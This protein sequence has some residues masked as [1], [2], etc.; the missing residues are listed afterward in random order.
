[1]LTRKQMRLLRLIH[2]FV[3]R[4]G[5]A[6]S[7][8]EMRDSLQLRSKS[9]VHRMVAAL[10]EKGYIRKLEHRARAI[11]VLPRALEVL[12]S[13]ARA[14]AAI[15]ESALPVPLMGRIAAGVP[16]EAVP[17]GAMEVQVP[18]DLLGR[19]EHYALEIVGDS[20]TGLGIMDGDTVIVEKRSTAEN[21]EV[22]VALVDQSEATLKR[23][24]RRKGVIELRAANPEHPDRRLPPERVQVQGRLRALMRRY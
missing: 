15:A 22:V 20:M 3:E 24:F 12:R 1:M 5:I 19:G 18:P 7:F 21:G 10:K 23:F 16:L 6:P 2:D 4:T 17:D 13:T 11:E 8:E 14:P 9:G